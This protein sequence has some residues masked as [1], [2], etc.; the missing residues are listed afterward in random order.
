MPECI[1][2]V[3][4]SKDKIRKFLAESTLDPVKIYFRGEPGIVKS[5]G[6]N[7]TSG[8]NISLSESTGTSIKRQTNQVIKF[9]ESHRSDFDRLNAFRFKSS[10]LD[11]GLYDLST[12]DYPWPSYRISK[13]LLILAA[14]F[15]LEIE[16]SFYGKP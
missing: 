15:G 6:P 13:K 14:E 3:T 12:D 1:L 11:F 16:L 5:R 4:G 9:I 7:K 8:F 2:R 10:T